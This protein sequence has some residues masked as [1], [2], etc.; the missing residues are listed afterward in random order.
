MPEAHT[1]INLQE[2]L[3]STLFQWGL[4][5]EKQLQIVVRILNWLASYWAG[6]I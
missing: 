6:N 5:P 4:D 2:A 3:E 1:G